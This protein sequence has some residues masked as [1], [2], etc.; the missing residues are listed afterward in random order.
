[1]P[2]LMRGA[3]NFIILCSAIGEGNSFGEVALID[4]TCI[5][6][7]TILADEA[8]DLLVVDKPLYN[9]C[10]KE[11]LAKEFQEKRE[12]IVS[13]PL[14]STWSPKYRKQ[15]IM[16]LYKETYSYN[17]TLVKQGDSVECMYFILRY[18]H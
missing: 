4:E 10:V 8:T 7:A 1:M 11:I 3:H 17:T 6:T 14:F 2:N 18:A 9:R 15:L 16:A 5:R 13:N 12:S